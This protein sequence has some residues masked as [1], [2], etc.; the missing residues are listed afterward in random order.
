M[1]IQTAFVGKLLVSYRQRDLWA[2]IDRRNR[3]LDCSTDK[4]LIHICQENPAPR[5]LHGVRQC[6]VDEEKR[7]ERE[8]KT[9]TQTIRD[10]LHTHAHTHKHTHT[11]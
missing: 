11:W 6:A 4:R 5:P 10:A 7:A 2:E 9:D 3:P 8:R 1:M